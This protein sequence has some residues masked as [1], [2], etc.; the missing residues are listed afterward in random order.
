MR[1]LL[2]QVFSF[3][4]IGFVNAGVDTAMFFL[5]LRFVTDNLV[6]ANICAW[7]IAVSCSY[8]LNSRF[9]FGKPFRLKDYLFFAT[10]QI[11][12][13]VAN[14]TALVLTAPLVPLL[15]AKIIAIGFGFV[16]NFTLARFIVFRAPK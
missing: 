7:V 11:G 2:K 5:A 8:M 4:L 16:V 14:T 13:L 10:T 15:V 9:T 12:G 6:V 1:A 3:G